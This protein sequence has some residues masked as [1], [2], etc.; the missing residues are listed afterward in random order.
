MALK[1]SGRRNKGRRATPFMMGLRSEMELY[2]T[3]RM[4]QRCHQQLQ[5]YEDLQGHRGTLH[6]FRA[7]RHRDPPAHRDPLVRGAILERHIHQ[8]YLYGAVI[9]SATCSCRS[10]AVDLVIVG[11]DPPGKR[12]MEPSQVM[13][14]NHLSHS[15]HLY[16]NSCKSL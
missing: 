13:Q 10:R 14:T 6:P 3:S 15:S 5:G 8:T 9:D 16:P 7:V 11:I 12:G 1:N 2:Q 4:V